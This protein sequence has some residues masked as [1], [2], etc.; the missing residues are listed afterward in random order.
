MY[1]IK[2][3]LTACALTLPIES[4]TLEPQEV[5]ERP[6][7]AGLGQFVSIV[8]IVTPVNATVAVR[9]T[10]PNGTMLNE[11]S[12]GRFFVD[13]GAETGELTVILVITTQLSYQDAG[14]YTCEVMEPGAEWIPATVE[15]QLTGEYTFQIVDVPYDENEKEYIV[16]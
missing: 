5:V 3:V 14:D 9:W 16:A 11:G 4:I 15:L 13:Q 1:H 2:Y 7:T 10:L 12:S 6:G 8:C